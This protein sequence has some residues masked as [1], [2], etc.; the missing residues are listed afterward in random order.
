[1]S[2]DFQAW[3]AATVRGDDAAAWAVNDATLQARDLTTRDDPR[4]PYHRRWVWNG[5]AFDGRH[6]LVRCYHGLG[7]TL[8]FV[9]FLPALRTRAASVVLEAQPELVA[10]LR[11]SGLGP[12]EP[13]VQD[14]PAAPA[15]VDIEVMELSAC[16][17]LAAGERIATLYRGFSPDFCAR[18]DRA[19]LAG[20]VVGS[21]ALHPES[22]LAPLSARPCVA[23]QR[24]VGD[25]DIGHTAALIAGLD[26]VITVDTMVAHLAGA[27]GRPTWLLLKHAADWR[28]YPQGTASR[29]YPSMRLFRQPR[30]GGLVR[31]DYC[32]RGSLACAEGRAS[33]LKK[34]SKKL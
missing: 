18:Y 13:F 12:I 21:G 6:V 8:Q 1:M 27:L 17:A 3:L 33:F 7:D 11:A 34:R 10:L 20:G 24:R 32:G 19:V 28:W 31:C 25:W 5:D 9:R 2:P 16:P 22:L 14:A 23:L 4:L 30:A 29:W 26:L 15:E